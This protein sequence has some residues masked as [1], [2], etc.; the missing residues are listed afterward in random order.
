MSSELLDALTILEREKG[1]SRDV[2]IDAIEAA[3]VSAYR[4]NFNQ[5]QNVRID[6]NLQTG[7]MRVFARKEVVDQVFDPR[8]EISLADAR[9]INPNYSVED[10]VE[11]EVTPKDFGRIAAQTAKQVVTQRV[12]EAER[13]II[14][15]EFIDREEDIMTG[16]V[17]RLDSKF[18]YVSLG[19][20]EALLAC[21]RTNAK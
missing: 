2:L 21:K 17:Q 13:G 19:K 18:I 7:T 6:L 14:Y 15:S 12:R 20:I 11:M 4:R 9:N 5:A 1:I 3:L 16:I 10:I 8:L